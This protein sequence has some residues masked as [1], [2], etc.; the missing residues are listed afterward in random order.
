MNEL[1]TADLDAARA[2]Y[3]P[4][5]GWTTVD[6]DTG[7][8]GPAMAFAQ[9]DGRNNASMFGAPG[10][11]PHWRACFTVASAQEAA[12]RV[13]ALG[14]TVHAMLPVDEGSLAVADDPQGARFS[15]FEGQTDD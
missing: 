9:L 15:L 4:L 3:E 1:M 8:D 2:F 10:E 7:P 6:V 14:G 11:P 12:E 5:F 13:R